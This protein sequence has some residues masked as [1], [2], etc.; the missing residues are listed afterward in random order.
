MIPLD[1]GYRRRFLRD[2]SIDLFVLPR[3]AVTCWFLASTRQS[4]RGAA[5]IGW[6]PKETL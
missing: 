3:K 2:I 5:E 4:L 6:E 1:F